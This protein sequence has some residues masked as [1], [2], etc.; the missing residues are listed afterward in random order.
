[1]ATIRAERDKADMCAKAAV[2]ARYRSGEDTWTGPT[3]IAFEMRTSRVFKDA[4]V[5]GA[6]LKQYQDGLCHALLPHG[7][8]PKTPYV[9]Y[10]PTQVRVPHRRDEGV[11][12]KIKEIDVPVV[13][14]RTLE[15]FGFHYIECP[16]PKDTCACVYLART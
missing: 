4:L 15:P 13:R 3:E 9:W 10:P 2:R 6:S 7:D 8:G 16:F 14:G 12:V 1:M 11:M 5:V